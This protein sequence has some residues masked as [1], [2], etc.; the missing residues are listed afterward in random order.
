MEF[1]MIERT[2]TIEWNYIERNIAEKADILSRGA[3]FSDLREEIMMIPVEGTC[4]FIRGKYRERF[5]KA[6]QGKT[7]TIL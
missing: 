4:W 5:D 2:I 7:E 1:I 3:T 6:R